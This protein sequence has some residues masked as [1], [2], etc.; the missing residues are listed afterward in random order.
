M[1]VNFSFAKLTYQQRVL[2]CLLV[3]SAPAPPPHLRQ[4]IRDLLRM[5]HDVRHGMEALVY[6]YHQGWDK[7]L[8]LMPI[9]GDALETKI[10]WAIFGREK[11]DVH[12]VRM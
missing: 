10:N 2:G 6:S 7:V 3:L 12:I 9:P 8:I 1:Y 5:L 4:I 11:N